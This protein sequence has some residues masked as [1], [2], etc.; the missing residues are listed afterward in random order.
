MSARPA[1]ESALDV[2]DDGG[3][4]TTDERRDT[5]EVVAIVEDLLGGWDLA[6]SDDRRLGL[7]AHSLAFTRRIRDGESLPELDPVMFEE[8]DADVL[9]G[10][11]DALTPFCSARGASIA[12]EVVFLFATHVE[13]AR[14]AAA[15]PGT[16]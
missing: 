8:V 6:M 2:I 3:T 9:D 7:T 11:R 1:I 5:A 14:A 13:V 4:L 15:Q 16:A 10:L 12:P